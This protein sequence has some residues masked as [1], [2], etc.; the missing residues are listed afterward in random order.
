MPEDFRRELERF[1]AFYTS[2]FKR[3]RLTWYIHLSR[4]EVLICVL[5]LL[6]MRIYVPA[7]YYICA[8]IS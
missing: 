6:Y 7:Y 3:R 8:Y 4:A 1:H 5:I 2:K